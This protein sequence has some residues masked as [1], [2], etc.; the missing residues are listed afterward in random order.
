M[1]DVA[2]GGSHSRAADGGPDPSLAWWLASFH[3]TLFVAV[4]VALLHA[5]GALGDLLGGLGT[6]PGLV[7]FLWLWGATW[8]TNRRWLAS[9]D[10]LAA[11][12]GRD[13]GD[14][15][16]A[17]PGGAD[18]AR[19]DDSDDDSD[20]A[21][22]GSVLVGAFKWGG[23]TGLLFFYGLMVGIAVAVSEPVAVA[24][25]FAAGTVLSPVVGAL[26][27][28]VL[29]AFDLVLARVAWTLL[30]DSAGE[31]RWVGSR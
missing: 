8:A 29:A 19:G 6:L 17:G 18:G 14:E 11:A 22:P 15:A 16:S 12:S 24:V 7:L 10:P 23:V 30:P 13:G 9:S 2:A 1:G 27:G 20:S 26:V 21:Q 4:P 28:V 5:V 3:A 31:A 25:L